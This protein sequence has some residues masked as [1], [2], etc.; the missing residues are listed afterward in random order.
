VSR[1]GRPRRWCGCADTPYGHTPDWR[2]WTDQ[3]DRAF[4]ASCS[5]D[6]RPEPVNWL[7]AYACAEVDR[8]RSKFSTSRGSAAT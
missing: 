5:L 7:Y 2:V 4:C 1:P 3:P 6:I 8:L